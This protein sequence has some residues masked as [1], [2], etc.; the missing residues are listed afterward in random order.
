LFAVLEE[1][2]NAVANI[3]AQTSTSNF[4]SRQCKS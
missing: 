4:E 2:P 3:H 1:T